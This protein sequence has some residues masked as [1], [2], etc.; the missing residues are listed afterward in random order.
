MPLGRCSNP[1]A[2]T[3]HR[4]DVGSR[5]TGLSA[6]AWLLRVERCSAGLQRP[7]RRRVVVL[8]DSVP[9]RWGARGIP[10]LVDCATNSAY[11]SWVTVV[12]ESR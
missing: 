6:A 11:Y 3:L 2:H 4:F 12:G 5:Q 10:Q 1:G 7:E 9:Q 8:R